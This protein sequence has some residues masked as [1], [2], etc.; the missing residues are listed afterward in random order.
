MRIT[1]DERMNSLWL[2]TG[3]LVLLGASILACGG[4]NPP[5]VETQP[6]V[7]LVAQGESFS[8]L[9]AITENLGACDEADTNKK[10][11]VVFQCFREN[12][13][14]LYLKSSPTLMF[15]SVS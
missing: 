1:M 7:G 13:W 4:N 3:M 2:P 11:E 14:D 10:G 12:H 5:P 8:N 15:C 9:T 6:K